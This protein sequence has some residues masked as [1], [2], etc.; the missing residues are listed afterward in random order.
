MKIFVKKIPTVSIYFIIFAVI[1]VLMSSNDNENMGF[2]ASKPKICISDLDNS[3]ASKELVKFIEAKAEIIE[4]DT[5]EESVQ[6][7]LYYQTLDCLLTIKDGFEDKL[8]AGET[9][10]LFDSTKQPSTY[11]GE[12]VDSQLNQYISAVAMYTAS[13][14]EPAKA[15]S[16]A[17]ETAELSVDVTIESFG[18]DSKGDNYMIGH[19]TQYLAYIFICVLVQSLVPIITTFNKKTLRQRIDSSSIPVSR[20][21]AQVL[22]GASIVVT[23]VW[24][25]FMILGIAIYKGDMFSQN[26]LLAMLNSFVFILV[27]AGITLVI[28]Q[29][30]LNYNTL[31]M[32]SNVVSLGM[33]FL[34]GVFVPQSLLGSGVLT[35]A[36]FLPAYWFVRANNMLFGF[37]D[38]A[39]TKTKYFEYLGIELL[40]AAAL[41]CFVFVL[42]K[43]KMKSD[44]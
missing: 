40:F 22:A 15:C 7:A 13:G 18:K 1:G 19:F 23:A 17:A 10:D 39:F 33:S 44:E 28:A 16:A 41:F 30:D 42:A 12:L 9:D 3:E 14:Y 8:A 43:N 21:T 29:F 2:K 4:M 31:S 35:A 37:S 36:K 32:V 20:K 27:A 11:K 24:I 25:L 38:E 34:C 5:D 6:D 26:G